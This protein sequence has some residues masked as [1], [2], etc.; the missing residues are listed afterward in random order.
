MPFDK[1]LELH[2]FKPLG[3][4]STRFTILP[5]DP[6]RPQ[7]AAM[8]TRNDDGSFT[9][10]GDEEAYEFNGRTGRSSRATSAWCPPSTTT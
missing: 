8:Y 7:L 10:Q 4:T 2:I 5:T 9:R 6:D 1:F 3:M